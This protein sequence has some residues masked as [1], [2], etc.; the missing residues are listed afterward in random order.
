MYTKTK[1]LIID[2]ERTI[3]SLI[4]LHFETEG[5]IVYAASDIQ[6]GKKMP[7]NR[8]D[9]I[10]LDI[11]IPDKTEILITTAHMTADVNRVVEFV[12][13]LDGAPTIISGI[14]EDKV[15]LLNQ[16]SIVR[17]LCRNNLH[18]IYLTEK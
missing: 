17:M 18:G 3:C 14:R 6:E 4:K 13:R 1:L 16:E 15:E 9:L 11:N 2:D 8:P 12:S 10:L 7:S 5:Y